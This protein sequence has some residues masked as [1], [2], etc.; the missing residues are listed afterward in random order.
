MDA[1]PS[2]K[3]NYLL[4]MLVT[5]S[6][7]VFPLAVL[8]FAA[9]V[10]GPSSL[11]AFYFA[12]G[13]AT[14]FLAIA[15]GAIPFYGIREFGR[16]RG[17][18]PAMERLAGELTVLNLTLSLF[19]MVIYTAVVFATPR[20]RAEL[21]MFLVVGTMLPLQAL[22]VD[23]IFQGLEE[24]GGIA[25]RSLASKAA[26][27]A[28]LLIFVRGPGDELA[29][30]AIFAASGILSCGLGWLSLRRKIRLGFKG[31]D[32]RRHMAPLAPLLAFFL[33]ASVYLNLDSVLLGILSTQSEVG[34]YSIGVKTTRM[35]LTM[36]GAGSLSLMPRLAYFHE[37]SRHEEHSALEA[38]AL[39][40]IMFLASG[41]AM[42][43]IFGAPALMPFFFGPGFRDS[44]STVQITAPNILVVSLSGFLGIRILLSMG[45][46]SLFVWG[47]LAGAVTSLGLGIL[48]VP[49][50]GHAG[51]AIAW[52]CSETL[53][54]AIL[55]F[56]S[57]RHG[58][59][60][61]FFTARNGVYPLCAL[62]IAVP[63]ALA[64]H[65]KGPASPA[66]L[67]ALAAGS[68]LYLAALARLRPE[69]V[70]ELRSMAEKL[71]RKVRGN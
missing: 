54:F 4:N 67:A 66:V 64:A 45:K 23:Y 50:M 43:L 60:V 49:R 52:V 70:K 59:R 48:L 19:A 18:R 25:R 51:S 22:S 56:L 40:W 63:A 35:G 14:Y 58:I 20:F 21:P 39:E 17:D 24:Y 53:A 15:A 31:L 12:A 33:I 26:T 47:T 13:L 38:K 55:I 9:R 57:R 34:L 8:A 28:L 36:I 61:P 69:L 46:E 27:L 65:I 2:L 5:G 68:L 42:V 11:G 29:Y 32:L 10:L 1:L 6:N 62:L 16:L 30:A 71:V 7:I 44:A 37:Q 3:R 41:S